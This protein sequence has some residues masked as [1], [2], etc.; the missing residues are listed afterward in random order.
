MTGDP[1]DAKVRPPDAI[2]IRKPYSPG[3]LADSVG[4]A[5][6]GAAAS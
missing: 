1:A 2:V 6:D 5:L 4:R 3:S